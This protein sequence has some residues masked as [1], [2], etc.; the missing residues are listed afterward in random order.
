MAEGLTD[1][2]IFEALTGCV[3]GLSDCQVCPFNRMHRDEFES[4]VDVALQQAL[5]LINR[6][7]KERTELLFELNDSKGRTIS[8]F[9]QMAILEDETVKCFAKKLKEKQKRIGITYN[10]DYDVVFVSD[11]DNLVKEWVGDSDG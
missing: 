11:I 2:E 5:V 1:S 10:L 7:K 4:C 9:R 8:A 6:L 3:E